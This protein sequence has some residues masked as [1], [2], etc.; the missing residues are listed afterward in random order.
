[1][2]RLPCPI[3]NAYLACTI[4][5]ELALVMSHPTGHLLSPLKAGQ[6]LITGQGM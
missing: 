6:K 5:H 2:S 3:A 1:M 4:K